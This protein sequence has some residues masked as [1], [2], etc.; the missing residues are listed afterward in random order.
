M[1]I[2]FRQANVRI[3]RTGRYT[4]LKM[5]EVIR[6]LNMVELMLRKTENSMRI[7][8]GISEK[9]KVKKGLRQGEPLSSI[10]FSFTLEYVIRR[11]NIN[12]SCMLHH[13]ILARSKR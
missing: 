6:K 1:F 2:N 11:G 7:K 13:N 8:Q 3:K 10:L 5:L 12:R 9:F 4:A